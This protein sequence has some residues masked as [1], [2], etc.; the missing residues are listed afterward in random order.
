MITWK[1]PLIGYEWLV[2][3]IWYL[4]VSDEEPTTLRPNLI[5]NPRA[6]IVFTPPDQ[7]YHYTRSSQLFAG[8][9]SHL[10]TASEYLLNL[11]D[12]PPLQ[13]IGITLRPEG[14]YLFNTKAATQI[15]QCFWAGWI[16]EQFPAHFHASL[17]QCANKNEV[18]RYLETYFKSI[19]FNLNQDKAFKLTQTANIHLDKDSQ[20]LTIPEIANLC[21]CSRRTLE[22]SFRQ[23]TG[24]SLKKYQMLLKLERMVLAL[25]GEEGNVDWA[26]FSQQFGFTDQSHLIRALKQQ[27][28]RTPSHYL[29]N[30]DLT[31][32]IYGDFE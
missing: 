6:H 32:D 4:Q 14:L 11:N 25:Y 31:I 22:R 18:A 20:S 30:R 19:N 15:N 16:N 21:A 27:L 12:H 8:K 26:A 13:R 7:P 28:M 23:V 2:H 17:W 24:L 29:K 9:G 5:P 10:L 3:Q 1:Q